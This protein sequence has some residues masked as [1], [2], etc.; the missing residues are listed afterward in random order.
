MKIGFASD[1]RGYN[2]KNKLI[3]T[4]QN[5]YDVY[6]YGTFSEESVDYPTYAFALCEKISEEIELGILICGTG[7]GISIAANKVKGI[8]CAKIS[9]VSEAILCKEHNNANVIAF[10]ENIGE[11]DAIEM[12]QAFLNTPFSNDERHKKRLRKI[13]EY[14]HQH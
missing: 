5:T 3:E 10:G 8:R 2:L 9:N 7:I 1:H 13:E 11:K 14:E 6:D 12:V 4:F